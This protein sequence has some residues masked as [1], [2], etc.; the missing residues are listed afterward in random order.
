MTEAQALPSKAHIA[1]SFSRAAATYDAV[2]ELQRD[3]GERLLTLM[4]AHHVSRWADLGCGTGYFSRQLQQRFTASHGVAVDI[5]QGML[6]HAC[7]QR[8][9]THY[10]AG[11]AEALPL[12]DASVDVV[13]SSLAVQWCGDFAQVLAEARR[14][15]KPGGVLAFS[16]LCHGTLA[17]LRASWQAV[18]GSVHVNRFRHWVDYQQLCAASGLQV[19]HLERHAHVQHFADLRGLTRSLKELGAHNVNPGRPEGLTGRARLRALREQYE[20]Y[21]QSGG[22]PAT[23]QVVYGVLRKPMEAFS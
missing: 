10:I 4:P 18:D 20:A 2:A 12:R 3:V 13:F 15:L 8:S 11:D 23:Y 22:L 19:S 1:A 14:V 5:A 16:S 9:A 17:E 7:S 6:R 21:R